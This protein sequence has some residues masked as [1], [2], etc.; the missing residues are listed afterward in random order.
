MFAGV[1]GGMLG[2]A[3]GYLNML[4][5]L[6]MVFVGIK[7]YRDEV[8]GGVIRFG[9]AFLVGLGIAAVGCIGYVVGWEAYLAATGYDFMEKYSESYLAGMARNGASAAEV[10]AA[11]AMMQDYIVS[12]RNPVMRMGMTLM[13]IAPVALLVT[14]ASAGLLRNPR[15]L[16]ARG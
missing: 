16:P 7:R 3:I 11:R 1:E 12:Y 10:A 14:L 4:I 9:T 15:F 13:E 2:M 8:Q 6:S 5:A